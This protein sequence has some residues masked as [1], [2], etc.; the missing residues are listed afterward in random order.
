MT[1]QMIIRL[2]PQTKSK[3]I[4][5]ARAEGKNTS[6]V[7]RE[8]IENY[9]QN[10]DMASHVDDLWDRVGKELQARNV[11]AKQI[12]RAIDESRAAGK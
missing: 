11:G 2:H 3:L 1:A 9:I 5:L 6:Q 7:V 12:K 8:L 10:R 4:E